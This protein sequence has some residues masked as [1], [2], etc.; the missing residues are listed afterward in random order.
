MLATGAPL[1]H[2]AGKRMKVQTGP[3]QIPA[4]KKKSRRT[5]AKSCREL[6]SDSRLT[7]AELSEDKA[8]R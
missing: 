4:E 2:T 8:I 5:V 7:A 6:S 3:A 1:N